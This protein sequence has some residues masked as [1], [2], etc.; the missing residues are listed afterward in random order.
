MRD[1]YLADHIDDETDT[2]SV[3]SEI[4]FPGR[5]VVQAEEVTGIPEPAKRIDVG[6]YS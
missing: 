3:T 1:R 5:I 2:E 6:N 4:L